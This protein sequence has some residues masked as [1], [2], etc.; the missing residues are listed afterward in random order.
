MK[1]TKLFLILVLFVSL[2]SC[3]GKETAEGQTKE[4]KID[5]P[6]Q[7]YEKVLKDLGIP[8]YDGAVYCEVKISEHYGNNVIEYSLP[9]GEGTA[10][11]NAKQAEIKL[12]NFY[13]I[14]LEKILIPKGWMRSSGADRNRMMYIKPGKE[15]KMFSV[16]ISPTFKNNIDKPKKFLFNYSE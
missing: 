15:M 13:E 10:F 12:I 5:K 14:Q 1:F 11:K 16:S 4:V 8:I 3:G 7:D 9:I 6:R 2:I